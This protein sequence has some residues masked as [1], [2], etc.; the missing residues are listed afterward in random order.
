MFTGELRLRPTHIYIGKKKR[1][2]LSKFDR[3]ELDYV[4]GRFNAC[5]A[6]LKKPVGLD[7]C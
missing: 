4:T 6:G 1:H 7:L 5:S 3:I 2:A